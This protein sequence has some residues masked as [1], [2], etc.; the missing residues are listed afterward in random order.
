MRKQIETITQN[1]TCIINEH[2]NNPKV[3]INQRYQYIAFNTNA[4][5]NVDVTNIS[6]ILLT[7]NLPLQLILIKL[8]D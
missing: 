1:T 4:L 6:N 2:F 8:R 5:H 7:D 3:K